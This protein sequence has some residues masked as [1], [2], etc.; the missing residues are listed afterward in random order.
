MADRTLC[1]ARAQRYCL[2]VRT[3]LSPAAPGPVVLAVAGDVDLESADQ[4]RAAGE[5][6]L[7][8]STAGRLRIDLSAVSFIDST[9]LGALIHIRNLAPDQVVLVAP[10]ERVLRLLE[11]AGLD[12]VF[13]IERAGDVP[14]APSSPHDEPAALDGPLNPA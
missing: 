5:Q 10:A 6:A 13:D 7:A 11:I 12:G 1:G 4:L 2:R 9:G 8:S 14:R 3:T